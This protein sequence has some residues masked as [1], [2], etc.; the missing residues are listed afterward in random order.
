MINSA[1]HK[2]MQLIN[3][4]MGKEPWYKYYGNR[5]KINYPDLTIYEL[6]EKTAKSYPLYNAFE[7]Y[8][9]KILYR[10]FIVR[11]KKTASSLIELGVKE[12]DRVTICMPNTPTAIIMFYAINMVGA[13]AN[14][15][16]P[17][18][19]KNE[20]EFYLNESNSKYILVID[21]VYDKLKEII[22]NT[23]VQKVIVSSVSDDM[24]R[25]KHAMY[26]FFSGRKNKI[27]KDEKAIFYNEFIKLG[28]YDKDLKAVKRGM[29]DE[30]VILYSGGTSGEPKG[31][32]LTNRNFNALAMQ[33]H[34]VCDPAKAGDSILAI[35][36]IFHGFGL[37][38]S[39]HTSLY[40]GV[41]V[42]LVPDFS[43]KK[44]G[45]LLKK[46]NPSLIT[47]VPTLF[48]AL[49]K[50]K[51]GKNDLSNLYC[52][53]SGGDVLL[54]EFKKEVDKFLYEHGS[55]AKVRCGY[56]LTESTG[57]CCL[58]PREEMRDNSIGI[59]MP[60]TDFKI[61]EVGTAKELDYGED[62]EIIISGPTVMKEY[63]N[64]KKETNQVLFEDKG[65]IWLRTGDI[66]CMDKDG[67]VYFKQRLKRIIVSSG[68]NIYP[69]Y[70]ERIILSHPMVDACVVI[71]IDHPYKK[72]VAKA[73][74][75]LKKDIK[76]TGNVRRQIKKYCE[77]NLVRYSWPYE[78]E[79][80]DS[81][82]TTLVGKVAYRELEKENR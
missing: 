11:I 58:N 10:D 24:S 57:A 59:P 9:K 47:G 73:Y 25:F 29:D 33:C 42:I 77:E 76:D 5:K 28:V 45:S 26:W 31:I 52:V 72:Q 56:G 23:K 79:Y 14:M 37:G 2:F 43:P 18:S 50:T 13:T 71:G 19:S 60:D 63:L 17:L 51:L 39:I 7:Y 78:Y 81:L 46:Y 12:G 8:G 53:I 80:R 16:H 15:I 30:A 66:G 21:L 41:K 64:N 40:A 48:E 69:S 35:L 20:I 62:G 22:A 75:V 68:Y 27:V 4:F 65:K 49:L 70:V 6:I 74:I 32:I 38:V 54:P 36:P 55:K 3:K 1:F 67:F 34:I 44:F 82:P 61:V